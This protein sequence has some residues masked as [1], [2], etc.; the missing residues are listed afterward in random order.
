M[1]WENGVN[2]V[3]RR[4]EQAI[5]AYNLFEAPFMLALFHETRT[6]LF[7]SFAHVRAYPCWRQTFRILCWFIDRYFDDNTVSAV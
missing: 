5:L 6:L 4:P 7:H 3:F 2:F 1:K